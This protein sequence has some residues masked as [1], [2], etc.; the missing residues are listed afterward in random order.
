MLGWEQLC[1]VVPELQVVDLVELLDRIA[2]DDVTDIVVQV[3]EEFAGALQMCQML[4]RRSAAH[5]HLVCRSLSVDEAARVVEVGVRSVHD[6]AEGWSALIARF[7]PRRAAT[8]SAAGPA[9]QGTLLGSLRLDVEETKVFVGSRQLA[10]TPTEFAILQVLCGRPFE[11]VYREQ[12]V[13]SV[14]RSGS[15]GSSGVLNTHIANLRAKLAEAGCDHSIVSVRGTG[16]Y[17]DHFP[18]EH[19]EPGLAN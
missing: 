7:E 15:R 8:G 12:V 9:D 17:L 1:S 5:V 16:F 2:D 4:M 19:V 3:S 11:I 14:W 18:P 13:A 10:V 6:M